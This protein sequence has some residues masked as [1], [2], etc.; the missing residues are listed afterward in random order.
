ML[1][2]LTLFVQRMFPPKT[3]RLRGQEELTFLQQEVISERK[4]GREDIAVLYGKFAD[5][6]YK[7]G[8]DVNQGFKRGELD[9]LV[10]EVIDLAKKYA[11]PNVING[12]IHTGALQRYLELTK[13]RL[14]FS[15]RQDSA[16]R[17]A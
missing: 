11:N 9:H 1:K 16:N 12:F 14:Q 3:I 6:G 7:D 10:Q 17:A 5:L 2:P 13:E 15:T 8:W 4:K